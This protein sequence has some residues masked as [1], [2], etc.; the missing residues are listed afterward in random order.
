MNSAASV[1]VSASTSVKDI[2]ALQEDTLVEALSHFSLTELDDF[3][4]VSPTFHS[5]CNRRKQFIHNCLSKGK[6]VEIVNLNSKKG[7]EINGRLAIIDGKVGTNGRYPVKIHHLT[8]EAERMGIKP[9]N[10]NPFLK[11]EQEFFESNRL[12]FINYSSD[13]K[14]R[15]GH[16]RLLDQVLMLLRYA[17]NEMN[18]RSFFKGDFQSFM[19]LGRSD[20]RVAAA[21]AQVFTMYRVK[22]SLANYKTSP[23]ND[24][25]LLDKT[26]KSLA[27]NERQSIDYFGK[28]AK[29]DKDGPGGKLVVRNMAR[30]L[31]TW[32]EERIHGEF[33]ISKIAPA[34]TL[35][36]QRIE[37]EEDGIGN[38]NKK[39]G[40]VYLVK[41]IGSQVG[42]QVPASALPILIRTT[43]LPMYNFLVY[44]GLLVA[45]QA[46]TSQATRKNIK[47]H[48]EKAVREQ[49][50]VYC[51]ESAKR[52]LWNTDPPELFEYDNTPGGC[53]SKIN[54][55]D[56]ITGG[57][58]YEYDPTPSQ[59]K[60][61]TKLV[62]FASD[63]GFKASDD[64]G[65]ILVVR[66][67]AYRK[68]D[69]PKQLF[70]LSFAQDPS[71][72]HLFSFKKWPT[73]SLDELLPHIF[74]MVKRTNSV[75]CLIWM[76][77]KSLVRP[78]RDLLERACGSVGFHEKV[79][80]EWYPPPSEEEESFRKMMR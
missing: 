29:Y 26:I 80:V 18:G 20:Q 35:V 67:L 8:G 71:P 59:L 31:R 73:Y 9:Q 63:V 19:N 15:E 65:C 70:G 24:C 25:S 1:S 13:A 27:S 77:E 11:K 4:K 14:I 62:K 33:W 48:V 6:S 55:Q 12:K 47:S 60:L 30:F 40:K 75:P 68:R 45:S 58:N 41:G 46:S 37:Q 34:G 49:N 21:N 66:R 64:N 17:I 36:V 23:E 22:P 78:L 52:G 5:A 7:M 56:S 32:D 51:G 2:T 39:L 50:V 43:F 79:K 42:E 38:T 54:E 53:D 3:R 61:A 44:D 72:P 74:Q 10:L 16:G 28:M 57:D 69:N 76:D